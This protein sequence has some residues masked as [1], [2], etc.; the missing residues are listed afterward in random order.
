MGGSDPETGIKHGLHL[1][2]GEGPGAGPPGRT[3]QCL[4]TG[5]TKALESEAGFSIGWAIQK[6]WCRGWVC[7]EMAGLWLTRVPAGNSRA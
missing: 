3:N 5:V 4:G 7:C 1:P 6:T 2:L